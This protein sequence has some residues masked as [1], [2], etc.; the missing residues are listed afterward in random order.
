MKDGDFNSSYFHNMVK[1]KVSKNRID[2]VNDDFGN[3]FHGSDVA[4]K[5]VDNFKTFLGTYDVIFRIED[6]GSLFTTKQGF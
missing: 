3:S 6:I 2:V 1:G 4:L 5:F